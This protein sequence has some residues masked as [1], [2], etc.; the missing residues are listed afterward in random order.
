[1][2]W[3]EMRGARELVVAQSPLAGHRRPLTAQPHPTPPSS[4]HRLSPRSQEVAGVD[5]LGA[6]GRGNS[7]EI[8]TY[9]EAALAT[10]MSGNVVDLCP[11]GA[12]TSKP[13]AFA[14]RSWEYRSTPSIDVLDGCAPSIKVREI[15]F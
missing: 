12:L 4:A 3:R 13:N 5:M 10:E 2:K 6:V 7:M 8:G 9:V 1:M 15:L 11:V 14:A